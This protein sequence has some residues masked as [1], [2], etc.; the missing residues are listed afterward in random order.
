LI[1]C[2]RLIEPSASVTTAIASSYPH[3]PA[4]L[5]ALLAEAEYANGFEYVLST[6]QMTVFQQIN[7]LLQEQLGAVGIRLQLQPVAASEWCARVVSGITGPELWHRHPKRHRGAARHCRRQRSGYRGQRGG[8]NP[9]VC[10]TD[11]GRGRGV[12]FHSA[13]KA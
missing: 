2:D 6:P 4:R 5:K 11:N 7:Q 3:D 8:T 1:T 10:R 13:S 12:S 9:K